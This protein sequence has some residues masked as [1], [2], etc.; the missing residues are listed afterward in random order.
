[1]GI[2]SRS[3]QPPPQPP[4]APQPREI[5]QLNPAFYQAA[6]VSAGKP[7]TPGNVAA[8]GGLTATN[9]ALN[10]NRWLDVVGTPA[11]CADWN[12][13]F[14]PTGNDP[15]RIVQRADEMIDFLWDFSPRLHPGLREFVDS[16]RETAASA[17]Q[18]FGDELPLD[19]W[20]A[21]K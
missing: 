1:M 9:L 8:I 13:R 19:M 12:A 21:T 5:P 6:L 14:G 11:A 7:V 16:M 2:F 4:S 3:K 18:A 10:A 20:G 17:S 15:A